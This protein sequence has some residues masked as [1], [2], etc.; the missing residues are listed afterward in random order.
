MRM[1]HSTEAAIVWAMGTGVTNK[2]SSLR[3]STLST[4]PR[5]S[6]GKTVTFAMP[7]S[8]S[9]E[10]SLPPAQ[11]RKKPDID[12]TFEMPPKRVRTRSKI[13]YSS[14][15]NFLALSPHD[16]RKKYKMEKRQRKLEE[17]RQRLR[18]PAH[19]RGESLA[20]GHD[21]RHPNPS[22]PTSQHWSDMD[23]ARTPTP[24]NEMET[25]IRDI[26]DQ[27]LRRPSP[28]W[29]SVWS[30]TSEGETE[31]TMSGS[32]HVPTSFKPFFLIPPN[33][34]LF[35][36][37]FL[38]FPLWIWGSFYPVTSPDGTKERWGGF[39]RSR[40]LQ[41]RSQE[42]ERDLE[43]GTPLTENRRRS[44]G[45]I[46]GWPADARRQPQFGANGDEIPGSKR[47]SAFLRE[48]QR[49]DIEDEESLNYWAFQRGMSLSPPP[50]INH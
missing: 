28:R 11:L 22:R 1:K 41:R 27:P 42:Q 43:K 29:K 30:T 35:V 38:L 44:D 9:E 37:G 21:S 24:S 14:D 26:R 6:L 10:N 33:A 36:G 32:V 12:L 40:I 15:P 18:S 2:R 47:L 25:F 50:F 13:D 17:R 23:L 39:F 3:F 45:P 4:N 7:P 20:T 16:L 8:D 31:S 49:D 48:S 5:L 19:S 46:Y 34:Y